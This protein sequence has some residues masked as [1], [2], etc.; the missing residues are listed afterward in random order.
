LPDLELYAL[1]RLNDAAPVEG[2]LLVREEGRARL[3][4][5]DE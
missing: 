2:R 5:R 1:G 3:A 4:G